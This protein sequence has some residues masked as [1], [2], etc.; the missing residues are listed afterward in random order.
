MTPTLTGVHYPTCDA[1]AC[2]GCYPD[3][4]LAPKPVRGP[5]PKRNAD[6]LSADQARTQENRDLLE[7]GV[8]PATRAPLAGKDRTCGGCAHAQRVSAG[9]W[10]GWKCDLHRLGM[11]HSA[12]SDIRVGWPACTRFEEAL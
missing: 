10:S 5:G 7:C 12:A 1:R 4:R 2:T 3:V 11:S 9:N 8:H 6:G